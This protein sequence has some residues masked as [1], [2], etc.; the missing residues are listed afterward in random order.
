MS[1]LKQI[2]LISVLL[3]QVFFK[4]ISVRALIVTV[5]FIHIIST[6]DE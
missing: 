2:T 3:T 6:E 4:V 5:A 1:T